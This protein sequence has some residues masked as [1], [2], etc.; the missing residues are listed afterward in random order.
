MLVTIET[1]PQVHGKLS[2]NS[3]QCMDQSCL[4]SLLYFS[5]TALI[6]LV[7]QLQQASIVII[8]ALTT[9]LYTTGPT[10]TTTD[11]SAAH[12]RKE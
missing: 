9:P 3:H 7:F 8:K 11:N 5:L 2:L 12:W 6:S 1:I 4:A 10:P